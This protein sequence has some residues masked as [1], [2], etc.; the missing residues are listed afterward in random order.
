MEDKTHQYDPRQ[1]ITDANEMWDGWSSD[2]SSV[3]HVPATPVINLAAGHPA[4]E[5]IPLE[6]VQEA[7][8][9]MTVA[10]LNYGADPGDTEVLAELACFL[11]DHYD[12]V[13]DPQSSV[14]AIGVDNLIVTGGASQAL[15]VLCST[16][17]H[18][19]HIP[20]AASPKQVPLQPKKLVFVETPTYH[21][22]LRIF[23][24][25]GYEVVSVACDEGGPI[26]A[27]IEEAVKQHGV[28]TF[29]YIIP[30]GMF[31]LWKN[32]QKFKVRIDPGFFSV[33]FTIKKSPFISLKHNVAALGV[34][35]YHQ[36]VHLLIK[37]SSL[38]L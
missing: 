22:A 10:A 35:G 27:S 4:A 25:H 37:R 28:P 30:T 16:L 15:D 3:Q 8:A 1:H 21:L 14:D 19:A 17:P 12:I 13:P 26:P 7:S 29:L 36:N 18:M 9:E 38:P 20:G 24:T 6:M 2:G 5:D 31:L 33:E 34:L 23:E 11:N 32:N